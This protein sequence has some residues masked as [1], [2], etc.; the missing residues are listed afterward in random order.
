MY[1]YLSV[2]SYVS[3]ESIQNREVERSVFQSTIDFL[4]GFLSRAF[5]LYLQRFFCKFFLKNHWPWK[6]ATLLIFRNILLRLTYLASQSK[7][8]V[9]HKGLLVEQDFSFWDVRAAGPV[10]KKNL[11]WWW[12]TFEG[13]FSCFQGQKNVIQI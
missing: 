10:L 7:Y 9:L 6:D 13:A 8:P 11:G 1:L 12:A 4:L 2:M 5:N 3:I